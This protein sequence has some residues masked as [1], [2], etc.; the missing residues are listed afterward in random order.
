[1]NGRN[2]GT[3]KVLAGE[4]YSEQEIWALSGNQNDKWTPVSIDI[5][6]SN[7]LVVC[8]NRRI[9]ISVSVIFQNVN[10]F[11]TKSRSKLN[12]NPIILVT[13]S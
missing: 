8:L 10:S 3:L 13:E 2:I 5:P 11:L 7:D 4:R 12:K 6:A 9:C 1:M